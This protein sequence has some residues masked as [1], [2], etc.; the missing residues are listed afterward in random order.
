MMNFI[1][2]ICI[3]ALIFYILNIE[4]EF[5]RKI[6]YLY[7]YFKIDQPTKNKNKKK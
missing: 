1:F 5:N 6:S 3:L 2:V 7:D 4:S